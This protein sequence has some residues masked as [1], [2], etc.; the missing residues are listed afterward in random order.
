MV[1]HVKLAFVFNAPFHILS[2]FQRPVGEAEAAV[3]YLA[4]ELAKLGHNI[5]IFS[6]T[7]KTIGAFDI[8]TR[9]I[10]IDDHT[11]NVDKAILEPDY[12]AIIIKNASPEFLISL[13]HA[14]PHKTKMYLWTE[15]DIDDPLNK[16]LF[17]EKEVNELSGIV[18]VSNWQR[19]RMIAK[20][21]IPHNKVSA[22]QYAISPF[23][24][25]L[26]IDGKEFLHDKSKDPALSYTAAPLSGLETLLEAYGDILNSYPAA[27]LSIYSGMHEFGEES[28]KIN[29]IYDTAS[30]LQG[31]DQVG[32]ISKIALAQALR[33]KTI[34]TFPA[35]TAETYNVDILEAMAA[36][37]YVL[38]SDAGCLKEYGHG[39]TKNIPVEDLNADHLDGYVSQVLTICQTQVHSSQAFFDYAFKQCVE[40]NR[41]HTWRIRARQWVQ[42]LT[43]EN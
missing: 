41:K 7:P 6:H 13:R 11:L 28:D 17:D 15:Y 23:F 36:G 25:N 29:K 34:L 37:V 38:T 14:M 18:C 21:P 24:E 22:I 16:G 30:N 10:G 4:I 40:I 2:P 19:E 5:T 33:S 43:A 32:S 31:I 27:S 9:N 3:A 35:T 1:E 42:M 20:A 8:R 12:D 39:F 26:F